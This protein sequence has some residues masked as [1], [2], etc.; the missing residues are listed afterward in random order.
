MCRAAHWLPITFIFTLAAAAEHHPHHAGG[1]GGGVQQM[2][3][4]GLPDAEATAG[5]LFEYRLDQLTG[6]AGDDDD[7]YGSAVDELPQR[8]PTL[9]VYQVHRHHHLKHS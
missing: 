2:D 8:Q 3:W 4:W 7:D 5:K 1:G 9:D 6:E